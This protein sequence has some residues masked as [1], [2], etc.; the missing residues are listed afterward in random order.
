MLGRAMEVGA[1]KH[2]MFHPKKI[3]T[4]GRVGNETSCCK[5]ACIYIKMLFFMSFEMNGNEKYPRRL[6]ET[7]NSSC[8]CQK[9]KIKATQIEI[10]I[11]FHVIIFVKSKEVSC[12]KK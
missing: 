12:K 2:R 9:S 1:L 7:K 5:L 4:Y 3:K 11:V 10:G 6:E 8:S